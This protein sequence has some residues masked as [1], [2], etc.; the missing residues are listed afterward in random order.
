MTDWGVKQIS[1]A[2]T[3]FNSKIWAVRFLKSNS[4]IATSL[5]LAVLLW[6]GNNAGTKWL[7]T[8]WPPIF[9]GAT[10][11]LFAGLILLALLRWTDWFGRLDKLTT[12]LKRQLWWRGGFSSGHLRGLLQL[13]I[14]LHFGFARGVVS[15]GIA[16]LGAAV[17][18]LSEQRMAKRTEIR[19]GVAGTCRRVRSI[20]ARAQND[21]GKTRRRIA[22]AGHEYPLDQLRSPMPRTGHEAKW[23]GNNRPY[24]V[25]GRSV[26]VALCSLGNLF[27]RLGLE[28]K[29]I[30]RFVLL[31]DCGQRGGVR[32]LE[33]RAASLAGQPRDAFQ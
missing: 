3:S 31:R 32:L 29:N 1:F 24:N 10:R 5:L 11:F 6:G 28:R 17:G 25:A 8:W 22:W 20:L 13:G 9:T 14:A 30:W 19:G 4:G 33:Q 18:R 12:E 2:P 15:G 23:C 16:G 7:V 26:V 21:G 27:R